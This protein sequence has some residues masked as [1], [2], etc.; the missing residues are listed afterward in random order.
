VRRSLRRTLAQLIAVRGALLAVVGAFVLIAA[1][2]APGP[3]PVDLIKVQPKALLPKTKLHSEFIVD[4]NKL[5]QVTRVHPSKSSGDRTFDTQTFGNATQ[6]FIRK[7]DG[8]AVVGSYRMVYDF[9]PATGKVR[10]E[11][12]LVKR[13]GVD[14]DAK[15]AATEL[16]EIAR[17]HT[18]EP[19]SAG[20]T[21]QPIPQGTIRAEGR[22]T[23]PDLPLIIPSPTR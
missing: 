20:R 4:I 8:S 23:L 5:G 14:P 12:L 6:A 9:T 17:R 18:P 7:P 11:A 10:R 19:S 1:T 3:T 21:S 16:E 2:P 15:G 22:T 13:G